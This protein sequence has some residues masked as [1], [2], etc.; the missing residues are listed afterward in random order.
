[1]T[2]YNPNGQ[3]SESDESSEYGDSDSN[4]SSTSGDV[5]QQCLVVCQQI[6]YLDLILLCSWASR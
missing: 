6:C 3:H 5:L 4:E 2:L 1:M